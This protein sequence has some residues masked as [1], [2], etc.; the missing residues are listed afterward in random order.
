MQILAGLNRRAGYATACMSYF[1]KRKQTFVTVD[2]SPVGISAILSQQPKHRYVN[3]QRIISYASRALSDVEKRY[4]QTEKE[5]LTIVQVV[6]HHQFLFGSDTLITDHKLLEVIYDQRNT[7][8]SARIERWV[9]RLQPYTFR[10]IYKSDANN[11]ADYLSRHPTHVSKHKTQEKMTEQYVNFVTKNSVPKALTLKEIIDA[12]NSDVTFAT[13]RDAVKTNKWNSPIVRPFKAV[14]N[15]LT[16]TTDGVVLRGTG[17][18]IPSSLQQRA[19]DIAYEVHF[20]I[21][22][23]KSLILE[24]IWLTQVDTIEHCITC[25][26]AGRMNPPEPLRMTE[27]PELQWRTVHIDVY[28]PLPTSEYPLVAVDRYSRFSEVEIVHSTRASTVIPKLDKMFT[29]H[30]ILYTIISD[31]G[32]PFNGDDY[33]RYL[34]ALVIQAKFCT[35]Y[36]PQVNA[37]VK[38]F[39]QPL[40]KALKT[41]TLEGRPWKQ[42][43]NRFLLQYRTT[44]HCS[45]GVSPSELLFNRVVKKKTP[46]INKKAVN[47]YSEARDKETENMQIRGETPERAI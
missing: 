22:K 31:N 2:A 6:E 10:I 32:P 47:R 5:A 46:V 23:T 36:W 17:I 34:K 26:A 38:R 40:G 3:H 13:L 37:T 11:P 12:T 42:E 7:K 20:G 43:L 25:Q 30:D 28:G 35:P 29:V 8:T 15:E 4:C 41:G 1:D 39:M 27:M 21:N 33:A 45:T 9:L 44:P 14:N 18:V 19:I 24:K 16:S